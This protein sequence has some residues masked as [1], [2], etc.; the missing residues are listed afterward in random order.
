MDFQRSTD[1]QYINQPTSMHVYVESNELSLD[2]LRL[3]LQIFANSLHHD[4]A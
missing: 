3:L 4:H 1:P 2:H